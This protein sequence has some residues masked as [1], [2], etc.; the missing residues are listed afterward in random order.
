MSDT[1]IDKTARQEGE[2]HGSESARRG[3]GCS[4][5]WLLVARTSTQHD[6]EETPPLGEGAFSSSCELN[7]K[8]MRRTVFSAR[9]SIASNTDA[10]VYPNRC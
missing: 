1:T 9:R 8:P 7:E 5:A 6:V 2:T 3:S 10:S 4:A